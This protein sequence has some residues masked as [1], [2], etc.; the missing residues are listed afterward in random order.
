MAKRGEIK[1]FFKKGGSE[2]E[3]IAVPALIFGEL[4]VHKMLSH[5][6]STPMEGTW[7][8]SHVRSGLKLGAP[9]EL[10][11]DARALAEKLQDRPEWAKIS[12]DGDYPDSVKFNALG[13]VVKEATYE[14]R[15][16][17]G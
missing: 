7:A 4:A 13:E 11:R 12:E 16:P 15:H 2:T 6:G 3:R 10:Q 9:F 5:D 1:V 8:V 14:V 17:E